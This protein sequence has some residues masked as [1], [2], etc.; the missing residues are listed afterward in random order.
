[1]DAFLAATAL[2]HDL[3]VVSRD[4]RGFRNTGARFINPFSHFGATGN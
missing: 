2:A 1:L 4:E 3:T